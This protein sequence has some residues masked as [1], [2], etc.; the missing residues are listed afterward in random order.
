[1]LNLETGR[2]GRRRCIKSTIIPT[3]L[4][5]RYRTLIQH[6]TSRQM[7]RL[8]NTLLFS[9]HRITDINVYKSKKHLDKWLRDIPHTPK[10]PIMEQQSVPKLI[11]Y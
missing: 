8:F 10:L 9:I 7:E 1:M 5:S 11:V 6:S 3:T 4:D 2:E